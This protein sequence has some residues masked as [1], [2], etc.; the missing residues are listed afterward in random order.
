MSEEPQC[1]LLAIIKT[2]PLIVKKYDSLVVK[3][4][5]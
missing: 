5:F 1:A 4:F 2:I 3:G